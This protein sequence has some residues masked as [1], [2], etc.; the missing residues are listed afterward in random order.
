[1]KQNKFKISLKE[2]G[3][4]SFI[5]GI[6]VFREYSDS[7]DDLLLKDSIQFLHHGIELLLKQL[8]VNHNEFLIFEDIK[9]LH[10]KQKQADEKGVE[11]FRLDSPPKTISYSQ[12]VE[13]VGVFIKPPEFTKKLEG[14]LSRLNKLRNQ[15]EHYELEADK[16]EIFR[17]FD[18][19]HKPLIDL[20]DARIGGIRGQVEELVSATSKDLASDIA[21]LNELDQEVQKV[22]CQ[23]SNQVVPGQLFQKKGSITLPHFKNVDLSFNHSEMNLEADIL[24]ENTQARWVVEIKRSLRPY[25]NPSDIVRIL[26]ANSLELGAQPWLIVF[27]EV[28]ERVQKDALEANIMITD[29]KNWDELKR[30][31]E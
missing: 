15:I 25:K 10:K 5:R 4:H 17:L 30:Q 9:N 1:M 22:M 2:N 18:V 20:F 26:L 16:E 24:A 13:R 29:L 28:P 19:I 6:E 3:V 7:L 12:A 14:M 31:L 21:K 11:L 8:L 23:F 27:D